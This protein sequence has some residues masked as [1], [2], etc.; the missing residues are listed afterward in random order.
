MKNIQSNFIQSKSTA[1]TNFRSSNFAMHGRK[2][3]SDHPKALL[4]YP[5]RTIPQLHPSFLQ[6][7][8]L[9][10]SCSSP[11]LT[12]EVIHIKSCKIMHS[13]RGRFRRP[14]SHDSDRRRKAAGV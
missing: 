5:T 3:N 8:P 14:E 6:T 2:T 9:L 1:L 10:A 12:I 4:R 7:A 13:V 11:C